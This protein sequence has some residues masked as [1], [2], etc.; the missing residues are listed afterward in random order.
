MERMPYVWAILAMFFAVAE[1]FTVGFFLICFSIGA[2]AAAV[3]GFL[4]FD[5]IVQLATFV[6]V[7]GLAVVSVRPLANRASTAAPN[8]VGIDRVLH[9]RAIV[10]EPIEP[11]AAQG[12]VRV[13][14]EEWLATSVTGEPIQSGVAVEVV[15]V[16]GTRLQVRP[17]NKQPTPIL[18]RES[19]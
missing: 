11:D 3:M 15:G 19:V 18:P 16:D 2:V 12:R 14:F 17:L 1:I 6:I 7:S 13:N 10:I 4:G 5:F 8:K 9:Q